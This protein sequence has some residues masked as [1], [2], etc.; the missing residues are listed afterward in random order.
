MAQPNQP[1]LSYK[2]IADA[3]TSFLEIAL[4]TILCIR[5][6]Y[7]PSTFTR[8]R[9]HS[10]PVYQ[11]RH[12]S[13]RAY[14][15][16]V[17]AAISP[18]IHQ[19]RLRRLTVVVKRVEDGLPLERMVFDLGYLGMGEGRKDVG[20]MGAPTADELG[21]MFR[22][23]LIKIAALDGQLLD[24]QGESTFA[25]VVETN[26]DLEPS[27]NSTEA[28]GPWTPALADDTLRPPGTQDSCTDKHEPLLSV[29]AVETGVI[30]LRLM[31][32]ECVAKTGVDRLRV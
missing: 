12:P 18:E 8:R 15:S 16:Q 9:A 14:I 2:E 22:G 21:L 1:G 11:S 20:L 17:I 10:V 31:V 29:K 27:A 5:N 6:I 30:D 23:L 24:N 32:Q 25:V 3:I 26:D 13:V 19:G 7:P 28:T 4:H